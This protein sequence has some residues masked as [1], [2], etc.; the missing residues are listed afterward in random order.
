MNTQLQK[1]MQFHPCS[2]KSTALVIYS[3]KKVSPFSTSSK[4]ATPKI[5]GSSTAVASTSI[6]NS[7][8]TVNK[9]NSTAM[10][11]YKS[12]ST[13]LV[14]TSSISTNRPTV[15]SASMDPSRMALV[16]YSSP[17]TSLVLT[18]HF[19]TSLD[20]DNDWIVGFTDAEGC[21]FVGISYKKRS[22]GSTYYWDIQT[23][24][25]IKLNI[26]DIDLLHK[27][28][29]KFGVGK[30]YSYEK[31]DKRNGFCIFR[32]GSVLELQN[33]IIPFFTKHCLLTQKRYDFEYFKQ[34]VELMASKDYLTEK[35]FIKVV[36]LRL[37]MNTK[38]PV[39][40]YEGEIIKIDKPNLP[41]ITV[42]DITPGW[43]SGF[44]DGDGCFFVVVSKRSLPRTGYRI[45]LLFHI[46]QHVKDIE[47]ITLIKD[48]FNVGKVVQEKNKP[49]VKF[50]VYDFKSM[51]DIIIPHFK[52]YPLQSNKYHDFNC[53]VTCSEFIKNKQHLVPK[54][55]LTIIE[56]K[57]QMNKY[58]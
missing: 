23:S 33:V 10:V 22:K 12:V 16:P 37:A 5:V 15:K 18:S 14:P 40:N 58:S 38:T 45:T 7:K 8:S 20:L 36:S 46:A 57:D 9:S 6:Y 25:V 11:V 28:Q 17:T 1:Q 35:G 43:I 3:P 47:L 29:K 32:V 42:N 48:Y 51:Y 52:N 30:I 56:L 39:K 49:H 55:I 27:I 54:N 4:T 24:F 41:P 31:N 50:I 21:F 26:R 44:T 19:S 34:V 53:F 13:S 2:N